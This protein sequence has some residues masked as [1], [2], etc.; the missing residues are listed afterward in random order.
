M[1]SGETISPDY[2]K[3]LRGTVAVYS[4]ADLKLSQPPKAIMSGNTLSAYAFRGK[5]RH[6]SLFYQ[7][8]L[9]VCNRTRQAIGSIT[10]TKP[11]G[12]GKQGSSALDSTETFGQPLSPTSSVR[13]SLSL[14]C[15][16]NVTV[17]LTARNEI[18]PD[19]G[20]NNLHTSVSYPFI[21][22][23]NREPRSIPTTPHL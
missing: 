20:E 17:F 15:R 19:N 21:M 16:S 3:G 9:S 2:R 7:S 8:S 12:F 4:E 1:T 10:R 13:A 5:F 11:L 14:H 23:T 18:G 6:G 22:F